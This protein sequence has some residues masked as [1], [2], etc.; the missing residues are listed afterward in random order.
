MQNLIDYYNKQHKGKKIFIG[1]A[2]YYS[3]ILN[4]LIIFMGAV[5]YY[6]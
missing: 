4:D 1:V 5:D 6:Q 3:I 2:I